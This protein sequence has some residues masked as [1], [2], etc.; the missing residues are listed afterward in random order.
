MKTLSHPLLPASEIEHLLEAEGGECLTL[1]MPTERGGRETRQN[2]IRFKN[3]Y[4]RARRRLGERGFSEEE[5]D[6]FLGEAESLVEDDPFWQHQGEGLALF[7]DERGLVVCRCEKSLAEAV[8][9]GARF[10]VLPVLPMLT[11]MDPVYVLALSA[12]HSA[13]FVLGEGG[14][15][16]VELVDVPTSLE[17]A[18]V[19]VEQEKQLQF[20]SQTSRH[21][22][23]GTGSGA[24]GRP[25]IF[26]GHGVGG[27]EAEHK[28][29]LAEYARMLDAGVVEVLEQVGQ[30]RATL[31][32]AA[33]EPLLSIYRR[34]SKYGGL[35][36]EVIAGSP[37]PLDVDALAADA[38]AIR[39]RLRLR[40][41]LAEA[42][43]Y[44][45]AA[46]GERTTDELKG[47]V[48]AAH[49]GRVQTLLVREGAMAMG[50][51]DADN[52][53]IEVGAAASD[54]PGKEDLLNLAALK[55]RRQGG[56]VHLLPDVAMPT[57]SDVAALLRYAG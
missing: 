6:A 52:G 22:A 2:A 54:N 50:I 45:A 38:V 3:L 39:E 55:T 15:S 1:M 25:A 46:G 57:E 35:S 5:I 49:E 40:A 36:E 31:V 56:S 17:E 30:K 23:A 16:P 41:G 28:M 13:L 32:L 24:G 48:L 20:H 7:V 8:M 47:V 10:Y 43:T 29:R 14:L 44:R 18:M 9:L 33:A 37:D 27:D 51:F 21:A 53:G 4:R 11:E 34:E 19:G 26:H 12:G 42:S